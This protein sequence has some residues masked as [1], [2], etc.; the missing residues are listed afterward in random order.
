MIE[1]MTCILS[2][3]VV[4]SAEMLSTC[5]NH[6]FSQLQR[7][8]LE[9]LLQMWFTLN[10]DIPSQEDG[11]GSSTF[12]PTVTP[13]IPLNQGAVTSL[14]SALSWHPSVSVRTW[15]LSFQTLSLL[16]NL[17]VSDGHSGDRSLA[18]VMISD[19]NMMNVLVKFL[20]GT[21][22]NGPVI[23]SQETQVCM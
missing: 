3:Q 13:N 7:I 2:V 10:H 22:Q 11:T 4:P 23:T 6:L 16:A 1:Y 20:S 9:T 19:T 21:C 12:D 18:I 5:F 14:L 15:L 17:R 8:D